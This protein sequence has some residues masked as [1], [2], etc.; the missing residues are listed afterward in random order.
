LDWGGGRGGGLPSPGMG[1]KKPL[2]GPI[3]RHD[4]RLHR[5]NYRSHYTTGEG[6]TYPWKTFLFL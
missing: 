1:V 4:D 6:P 5:G 3:L 2:T